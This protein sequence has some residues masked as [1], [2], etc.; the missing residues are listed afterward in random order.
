MTNQPSTPV[1]WLRTGTRNSRTIAMTRLRPTVAPVLAPPV[2]PNLPRPQLDEAD[3]QGE[4]DQPAHGTYPG[5]AVGDVGV[6]ELQERGVAVA[7]RR[8][9]GERRSVP[10][11]GNALG[12]AGQAEERLVADRAADV[13][14]DLG[15]GDGHDREVVTP[16]LQGRDTQDQRE[17]ER[18]AQ[19]HDHP[20]QQGTE[21]QGVDPQRGDAFLD[22]DRETVRAEQ[23]ERR[24]A[25]V[26]QA[27]EA[28]VDVEPDHRD[29]DGGRLRRDR[30]RHHPVEDLL[31]LIHLVSVS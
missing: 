4:H 9:V 30:A 6:V 21:S 7:E 29:R 5:R 18:Q 10:A 11:A 16:E 27:G 3:D 28:E 26:E 24:L 20:H 23:H 14:H 12:A 13:P 19:T 1:F 15:R 2:G 17:Q 8:Q 31:D 25:D 22:R